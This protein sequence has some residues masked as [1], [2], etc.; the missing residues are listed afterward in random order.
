MRLHHLA[1]RTRALDRLE[2]FYVGLLGLTVISRSARGVWLEAGG[3]IVMLENA[4]T[5]EP[6]PDASSM[7]LVC[8]A[9]APNDRAA[10]ERALENAAVALESATEFTLYFRDPDG[11]RVGLSHHPDPPISRA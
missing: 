10:R 1:L 11:R 9:I 4:D 3:T 8:F 5:T 2:A 6:A 7:E